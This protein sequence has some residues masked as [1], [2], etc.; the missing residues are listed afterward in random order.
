M[1]TRNAHPLGKITSTK[2]LFRTRDNPAKSRSIWRYCLV[3]FLATALVAAAC[4]GDDD[5][6]SEPTDL[7][8]SVDDNQGADQGTDSDSSTDN[9]ASAGSGTSSQSQDP[10]SGNQDSSGG[11]D[12]TPAPPPAE[13][14]YGGRAV[15]GLEAETGQ[16]WN[17]ATTQ[18]AAACHAVMRAIFDT[19]F[20][21][22]AD[23]V[24][25]PYILESATSNDDF[26]EWT[27]TLRPG[28]LFHDGTPADSAAL[29]RH[30]I[31]ISQGFLTGQVL[32]VLEDPANN[33]EIIDDLSILIRLR[34][35]VASF[36]DL[37]SGQLGYFVAPSQYDSENSAQN[38][39]GTGPFQFESWT[40]NEELVVTRNPS[41]WKQDSQGRQ[42][43]F[44]DEVVFRPIPDSDTRAAALASGDLNINQDNSPI[45]APEYAEEFNVLVEGEAFRDTTYVLINH[46]MAPFDDVRARRALALCTDQERY[47]ILRAGGN[48][49]VANGPFS[50]GTPGWLTDSGYPTYDPEVGRALWDE[51]GF[52]G[53]IGISAS[54][55]P[56]NRTSSELLAEVW[57]D[58]GIDIGITQVDQGQLITNAVAGNFQLVLWR[59]HNG[60]S[61]EIE[62]IWWHSE[63]A[64]VGFAVNAARIRN[65]EVDQIF[66]EARLTTDS[67]ELRQ[68]AEDLNR[69]FGEQVHN[70]WLLWSLW[71]IIYDDSLRNVGVVHIP[72]HGPALQTYNGRVN[73]AEVWRE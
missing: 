55:D 4:G 47:H 2:A 52:S 19:L 28:I 29:K 7:N 21:E 14:V 40:L 22:D 39:I 24:F 56:F 71:Q 63:N 5:S 45:D 73:F 20:Y 65:P 9:G 53:E 8:S 17:P 25:R 67:D 51:V 31:E 13:P 42:L 15:M 70:L 3:L 49:L 66:E 30:L 61:L 16:G 38:P 35:S 44:L 64:R 60:F 54:N 6:S 33:I 37:F 62:R 69:E 50:P 43:P 36:P 46:E 41:Y 72:D 12:E 1:K 57:G 32:A 27:F 59:N 48:T 58:C 26:T 11:S 10:S 23:G 18:C 34:T 68:L